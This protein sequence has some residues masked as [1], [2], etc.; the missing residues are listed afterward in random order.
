MADETG[1]YK[2]LH[3]LSPAQSIAIESLDT[4]ASHC[5]AAEA[6]SVSRTTVSRWATNHPAF[7][8]ELNRRKSD[9]AD[10]N[11]QR[12]DDLI[13]MSIETVARAV[14]DGDSSIAMAVL[15][16]L[17][18]NSITALH[19]PTDAE[20]FIEERRLALTSFPGQ[21]AAMDEL[22][23]KTLERAYEEILHDLD[24]ADPI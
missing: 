23:G 10:R 22:E 16:Q 5:E 6:A 8:A 21:T 12:I 11:A 1:R 3:Q 13:L 7:V 17:G 15:K 24:E 4:G 19:G 18:V 20:S 2:L 9:R 14:E